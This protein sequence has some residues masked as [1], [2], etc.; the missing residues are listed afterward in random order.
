MIFSAARWTMALSFSFRTR[1][2]ESQHY[3]MQNP[4]KKYFKNLV[5]EVGLRQTR[6]PAVTLVQIKLP[7]F[8]CTPNV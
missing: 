8:E 5:G 3:T 2:K 1:G 6:E 4:K 7:P